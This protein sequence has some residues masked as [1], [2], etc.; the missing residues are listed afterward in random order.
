MKHSE[1]SVIFLELDR[2]SE[3]DDDADV[4]GVSF[5]RES[6]RSSKYRSGFFSSSNPKVKPS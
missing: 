5:A 3:L 6:Q 1:S 4:E 2:M